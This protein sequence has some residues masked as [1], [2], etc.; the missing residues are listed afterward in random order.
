[1]TEHEKEQPPAWWI[2]DRRARREAEHEVKRQERAARREARRGAR[3]GEPAREPMTPVRIADAALAIIDSGGLD[4]L[5][6]RSLAQALGVGTMTLYWY[7]RD[8]DE[9]LDL[10]ADRLLAGVT[11]PTAAGDWQAAIREIASSVRAALLR[12][13]GA[14]PIVATRGS[15]GP[16]GLQV[17]EASIAVL[18]AAGFST[19]AA[20]DACSAVSNYITGFCVFEMTNAAGSGGGTPSASRASQ[21]VAL[22][23]PDRFPNLVA[24]APRLF[25]ASRDDRFAF[26]LECLIDGFA[27]RLGA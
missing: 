1:M 26:G 15:Y 19:E 10:V 13:P 18:R 8:K 16:N 14:A 12:H 22:L 21:Y 7:V 5:T 9:V 2:V 4:G 24:A 11:P 3:H 25:G 27:A 6:V 23:P 20:A 17:I